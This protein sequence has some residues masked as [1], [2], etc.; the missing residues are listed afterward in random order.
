M[1]SR[2]KLDH[3]TDPLALLHDVQETVNH[4]QERWMDGR[5]NGLSPEEAEKRAIALFGDISLIAKSLKQPWYVRL[6]FYERCRPMRYFVV[7]WGMLF[8]SFLATMHPHVP[9]LSMGFKVEAKGRQY[10]H[11]DQAAADIMEIVSPVQP[12]FLQNAIDAVFLGI[13]ALFSV[14]GL[15]GQLEED[16][17]YSMS[18][19]VGRHVALALTTL[20][21]V[22]YLMV[23]SYLTFTGFTNEP[24]FDRAAWL[25]YFGAHLCG[26]V[27]AGG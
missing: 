9:P 14:M 17:D 10:A 26:I 11:V 1:R 18:A 4:L 12:R 21:A 22:I 3:E 20:A 27:M 25:A 16:E 8:F 15:R 6:L 7:T 2:A 24:E 13:L 19:Q 5:E 23:P